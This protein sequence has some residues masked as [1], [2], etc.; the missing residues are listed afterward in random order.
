MLATWLGG[1]IGWAAG[2]FAST[3][4]P[5]AAATPV[6][7]GVMGICLGIAQWPFVAGRLSAS[8]RWIAASVL[9]WG[10]GFLVGADLSSLFGLEGVLFGLVTGMVTGAFLGALQWML[11]RRVASQAG[12][13]IPANILA[14]G[15]ALVYYRPSAWLGL[16][17]GALAGIVTAIV[18]LWLFHRPE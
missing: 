18:L 1:A 5:G 16:L 6:L 3:L 7:G 15:T 13:W 2:W 8:W 9:G 14:W 10:A 4:V 12:W 17:M 11:L